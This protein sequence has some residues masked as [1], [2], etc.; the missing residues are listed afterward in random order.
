MRSP[1]HVK[2]KNTISKRKVLY[3]NFNFQMQKNMRAFN[4]TDIYT[5]SQRT[6]TLFVG[7]V[8]LRY[9]HHT[10]LVLITECHNSYKHSQSPLINLHLDTKHKKQFT[11]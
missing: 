6:L 5:P 8:A 1:F 4:V 3:E 11:A 7:V 9:Q 10:A 2:C